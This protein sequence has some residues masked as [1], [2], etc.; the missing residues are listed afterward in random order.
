MPI[1]KNQKAFD[2][3]KY[4]EFEKKALLK[5][6]SK[7]DKLFL[8]IG[9]HLLHDGHASRVLPGYNS[10][11]KL[12]LIK[13][14]KSTGIIFCVNAKEL[15]LDRNWGNTKQ[16]IK[17]ISI[18]ELK[19]LK[20]HL[21]LIGL[22]IS[23]FSGEKKAIEFALLISKK[24]NI[25][26]YFNN[27]I[28]GYPNLKNNLF[29]DG[30][31]L[32]P[33][34]NTNKKIIVVTGAGANNGKMFFCLSQ[35]YHQTKKGKN[36]GYAKIETFPVWDLPV[37]HPINLA[38]MAATAD[39]KDK[40]MIDPFYKKKYKRKVV[41]YNRDIK[42][43]KVLKKLILKLSKKNNFM[44]NYNSPTEMGLNCVSEGFVDEKKIINASKKEILRRKKSFKEIK[45]K[46]AVKEINKLLDKIKN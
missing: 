24:F 28:K 19:E 37:N 8:E 30:F 17:D 41:N 10:K 23:R 38:Y 6:A 9:G 22:V 45:N 16:K 3:E 44:R 21:N 13:S 34:I 42:A 18:F 25:P 7:F 26:I 4:L 20:K 14:L 12:N 15:E 43:F 32:Q 33:K 35:I 36:A 11:N 31:D 1:R 40:V 5:R 27:E 39:I 29:K 46:M 2:N